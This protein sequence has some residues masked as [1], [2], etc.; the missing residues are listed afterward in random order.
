MAELVGKHEGR[1]YCLANIH[2]LDL[3]FYQE[4]NPPRAF[5]YEVMFLTEQL[6]FRTPLSEGLLIS[7]IAT[8]LTSYKT[9][10]L[11][12]KNLQKIERTLHHKRR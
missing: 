12:R 1:G 8:K 6:F 10:Q 5:Y 7:E 2:A 4:R 11:T 3:Q 9:S